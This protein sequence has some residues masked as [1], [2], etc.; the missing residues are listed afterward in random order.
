MAWH[1]AKDYCE[2]LGGHLARIDSQ[3]EFAFLT[4]L[5]FNQLSNLSHAKTS[6]GTY[7]IYID[8]SDEIQ[9]GV[10]IYSDGKQVDF[11]KMKYK[12]RNSKPYQYL[13]LDTDSGGIVFDSD[14]YRGAFIIEWDN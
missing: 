3:E 11:S 5:F 2:S 8:G 9:E 4:R 14:N 12:L 1:V 7:G 13:S 10:W 6:G